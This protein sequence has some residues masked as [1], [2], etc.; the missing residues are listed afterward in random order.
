VALALDLNFYFVAYPDEKVGVLKCQPVKAAPVA[1]G[2]LSRP[3]G[4][5]EPIAFSL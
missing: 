4:Q 5:N 3:M 2:A 1:I